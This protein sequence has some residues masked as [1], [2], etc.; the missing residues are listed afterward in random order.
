MRFYLKLISVFLVS[1]FLYAQTTDSV[2]VTFYYYPDDN[3][4]QV[5]LPGEFN[6]WTLNNST[7]MT[8]DP[9]TSIWSK[10]YRLR[11]G[12]PSPLPA[13]T[14]I[15]GAYQYKINDGNWFP[16]PLNP[17]QNPFDNNNSFLFIKDPTIHLLLPNSTVASGVIRT[18]FPEITAYIF[19]ATSSQVNISSISVTIDGNEYSIIGSDYD[20]IEKKLSFTVP[21]PLSDGEHELVLYAESTTGTSNTDTT[22]FTIQSLP[23][24]LQSLSAETWKG[25]WHL[26]GA[27]FKTDGGF[28]S[29]V[30]S[31]QIIRFDTTWNVQVNGGQFDTTLFLL[32]GNNYFKVKADVGGQMVTSDSINIFRKFETIPTAIAEL[33]YSGGSINFDGGSSTDPQGQQLTYLW[34]EDPG[35][36]ESLGIDGQTSNQTSASKPVTPGEYYVSLRV[37][38]TDQNIDSNRVSFVVDEMTN[39]V[40]ISGY[41]DNPEWVKNGRIYLMYFKAFTPTGTIAA[42][43][44]NL[45]YIKAMGFNIIWVL[46]ITEI[47]GDA[48]NQINIGYNIIDF[49]KVE[50]SLGT[51]ADY[52]QFVDRA[53]ELGIKVIQDITPNHTGHE[54]PIAQEALSFKEYSQYWHY[55]QTQNIPH[56]DNGLGICTTPEGIYYYCAFSFRLLN[57]DW[58]DLDARKYMLDIYEYW[59]SEFGIDGYRFDVYWGPHRKYGDSVFGT[60]I[61]NT[62]KHI[63]PDLF[64]LGEDDGVGVGTE[65]LYA[66]RGG[67]LDAAYDF[68]LYFDAVQNFGFN[69]AS[70]NTLH[71]RLNNDG[72]HPGE[73]SYYLRF[74]ETQDEDRITYKYDSFEKTM[75]IATAIFMAPGMP[76]I[77]NGQ[78]V[79]F[80]KG[81]GN[82]GE[83]DLNDRRRGIIDWNF[84]GKDLLTPHYQKLTQIRAQFPAFSQHRKDTNGDGSVTSADESDFDRITTGVAAVYSYLRPY[85]N[86]NGLAVMN[87]SPTQQVVSL[88]LSAANLKFD[89]GFQAG[90]TYWVNDHYNGTSVQALGSE[91][92]NLS[93]TLAPY[94]SAVFTIST[95]E[96][97]VNLPAL[98]PL[99]S[100]EE[101]N[102]VTPDNYT[103]F[104]NYPNPFN[105]TT[106]IRYQLPEAAF[107]NLKI[108]NLL[109]EKVATLVSGEQSGGNYEVEWNGRND[110]GTK[111][112]SGIYFYRIDAG[113][114]RQTMKMI[115]LK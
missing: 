69:T 66:D 105:P 85:T 63:R 74:M 39:E 53:H 54:H 87:F 46:P 112:S 58:R 42:A 77:L 12:G 32:D 31:A 79:G 115:M 20:P 34:K 25:S 62:L 6:G 86:S 91:L 1:T 95:Q 18:K 29:T 78:E 107:V 83:P 3:P 26:F 44:P 76:L 27:V 10:T 23:L 59:V 100:V 48:D 92:S 2:D 71:S 102:D 67:G 38:D 75:P 84:G 33:T 4:T 52:K 93:V 90:T 35:N 22:T 68:R 106:T 45:E 65:F 99:V 5:Y 114:F 30:T 40:K 73:N 96:E 13:A 49:L 56:N 14:S 41:E 51:E 16:D 94:G 98:P 11:V 57:Y 50:S 37:E 80:G 7:L 28:D 89:G 103:L 55:Y 101:D 97:M 43:I 81:M 24:Q 47:P 61:R 113:D 70:V 9:A 19:P 64:L 110:F 109:G 108:Y 21:T 88:N 8:K 17:R 111:L 104:Q 36:P 72:F 60:P 82:P 15:P